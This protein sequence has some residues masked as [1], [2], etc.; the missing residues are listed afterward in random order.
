[1]EGTITK[2]TNFGV[3][4]ELTPELEGLLHISELG[5]GEATAT[6]EESVKVGQ[7]I[8]VKVIKLD[9]KERKIGLTAINA[10]QA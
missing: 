1:M 7:K 5:G 2:V 10:P 9:A 8:K 6:P 4:V 3:F